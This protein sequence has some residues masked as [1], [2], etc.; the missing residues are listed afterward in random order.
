MPVLPVVVG[1]ETFTFAHRHPVVRVLEIPGCSGRYRLLWRVR[2]SPAE[3]SKLADIDAVTPIM[4]CT[5]GDVPDQVARFFQGFQDQFDHLEVCDRCIRANVVNLANRALLEHGERS[6]AMVDDVRIIP[7]LLTV[8]VDRQ[9]QS[10]KCIGAEQRHDL[11]EVLKWPDVVAAPRNRDW[12][13]KRHK[14]RNGQ[15]VGG[16]FAGAVRA[17]R[18]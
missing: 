16:G 2:W 14:V 1:L 11:L 12:Q 8:T 5:V 7:N 6:G 3:C 4:T 18:V 9:W 10:K 17:A 13:A 15:Q